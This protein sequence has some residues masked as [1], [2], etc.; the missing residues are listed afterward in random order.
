M[1]PKGERLEV[2]EAYVNM[3]L[4]Q[5]EWNQYH[6]RNIPTRLISNLGEASLMK[7]MGTEDTYPNKG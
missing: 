6:R 5:I 3:T 4:A 2:I 7:S 1:T